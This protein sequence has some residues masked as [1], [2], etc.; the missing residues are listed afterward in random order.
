M[1]C[2]IQGVL[3]LPVPAEGIIVSF[4]DDL[5]VVVT[6]NHPEYMESYVKETVRV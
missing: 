1:I 3:A 5:A 6:A 4:V 2:H